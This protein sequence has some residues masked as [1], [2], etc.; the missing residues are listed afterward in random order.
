[1]SW[2]KGQV[3]SYDILSAIVVFMITFGF[4]AFFWWSIATTTGEPRAGGLALE[5]R[6]VSDLLLSP[7]NPSDWWNGTQNGTVM[8]PANP[9]TWNG[10]YMLGL[11]KG[12]DGQEIDPD[13][14]AALVVMSETDY[15]ATKLK[16][17]TNYNFYVEVNEFYYCNETSIVNS[18]INCTDRGISPGDP[19]WD[20]MEHFA[21]ANGMN[22]SF[23][24]DWRANGARSVSVVNRYATYN[25][26][27]VLMRVI[28]WTNQTWQ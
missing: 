20:S 5:A 23:G 7:G 8:D 17:R 9:D 13:K 22:I 16:L 12:F 25:G 2:K 21:S 3:W 4:L 26:S 27:L 18:P 11:T 28:T 6:G 1:L 24:L 10:T 15:N 19:E 14:A